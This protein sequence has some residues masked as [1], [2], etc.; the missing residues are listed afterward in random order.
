MCVKFLI[1][2]NRPVSVVI[3][4]LE[5]LGSLHN[6]IYFVIKFRTVLETDN[7]NFTFDQTKISLSQTTYF[8]LFKTERVCR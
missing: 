6:N 7:P 8:G 2:Y 4:K 3:D 1:Q 5:W